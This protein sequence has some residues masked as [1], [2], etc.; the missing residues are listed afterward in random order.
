VC[1]EVGEQVTRRLDEFGSPG[2]TGVDDHEREVGL[3][4]CLP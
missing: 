1:R 4:A 3:Q 2:E